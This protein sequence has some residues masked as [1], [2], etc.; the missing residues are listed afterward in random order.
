MVMAE[1][2]RKGA[3]MKERQRE[4]RIVMIVVTLGILIPLAVALAAEIWG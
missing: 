3:T 4:Q 1:G 2:D